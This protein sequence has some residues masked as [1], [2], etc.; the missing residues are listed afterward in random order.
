M[1]FFLNLLYKKYSS[2]PLILHFYN[3]QISFLFSSLTILTSLPP[4]LIR[5]AR[6]QKVHIY[7]RYKQQLARLIQGSL[8]LLQIVYHIRKEQ[9]QDWWNPRILGISFS[10]LVWS[11]LFF[12]FVVFQLYFCYCWLFIIFKS[13]H[14]FLYLLT[15]F[16][17]FFI[18]IIKKVQF[19]KHTKKKVRKKQYKMI[20]SQ[21]TFH[22]KDKNKTSIAL[23]FIFFLLFFFLF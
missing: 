21:I 23:C 10:F 18:K 9:I 12:F 20:K 15:N 5:N 11:F 13:F 2:L 8:H 17:N 22:K 4:S 16:F 1:F 7:Y 19:N 6:I 3:L 14:F